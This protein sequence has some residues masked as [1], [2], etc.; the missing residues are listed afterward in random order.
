MGID[1][2]RLVLVFVVTAMWDVL[3]RFLSTGKIKIPVVSQWQWVRVLEP[4]FKKHTIL[5]AALLAGF[6]GSL[7]QLALWALP[8][9]ANPVLYSAQVA[10]VSAL[11]GWPMYVS[12]LYPELKKYYY[13][14]LGGSA[15]LSDALSGLVVMAS[16]Y[17][18]GAIVE[19]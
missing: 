2:E 1:Y 10:I 18:L 7:A 13:D 15:V 11:V 19:A 16:V 9:T 6:A 4:Y 17:V 8:A 5:G 14:R 12:G 3:L